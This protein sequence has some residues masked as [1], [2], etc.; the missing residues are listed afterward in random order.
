MATDFD[1]YHILG[2]DSS[3]SADDIWDAYSRLIGEF[4]VGTSRRS[5]IEV[6]YAVIGRP[7]QRREYDARISSRQGELSRGSLASVEVLRTEIEDHLRRGYHL[8][9]TTADSA[10]LTRRNNFAWGWA[11][12][13]LVLGVLP[14]VG[15]LL[16]YASKRVESAYIWID[17][18]GTV[19]RSNS[20]DQLSG[21]TL[22]ALGAERGV[23]AGSVPWTLGDIALAL[24]LPLLLIALNIGGGMTQDL[25]T[26]D[27]T[28]SDY[29]ISYAFTLVL[30][31]ALLLL[32]FHFAV[33]KYRGTFRSLGFVW[34][35]SRHWWL[36][37]AVLVAS[38]ATIMLYTFALSL[39]GVEAEGNVADKAFDY[40]SSA[41]LLT[42][43][44]VAAAP[45]AEEVFFRAFLYQGLARAWGV[46]PGILASAAMFGLLHASTPESLLI[47]PPITAIGAIFAWAYSRTGSIYPSLIAHIIFNSFAVAAGFVQ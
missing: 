27:F 41:I 3:A 45:L 21:A 28:E 13:W 17:S 44:S 20:A 14:F 37:L 16:Y 40:A 33:R 7:E 11:V 35:A 46:W 10:Y 9:T 18:T 31:V 24:I 43:V 34:P 39:V 8:V 5:E 42:I 15:Y 47:I 12:F 23:I 4:E 36:P 38:L 19:H 25:D 29:V 26:D 22:S 32:V 30:E 6:A 1:P 2:V